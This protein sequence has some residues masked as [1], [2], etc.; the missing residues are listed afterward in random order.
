M[1]HCYSLIVDKKSSY[2]RATFSATQGLLLSKK[3]STDVQSYLEIHRARENLFQFFNVIITL[4]SPL[5]TPTLFCWKVP[6][7]YEPPPPVTPLEELPTTPPPEYPP[8]APPARK[9]KLP[10]PNPPLDTGHVPPVRPLMKLYE[11]VIVGPIL[12]PPPLPLSPAPPPAKMLESTFPVLALQQT[13]TRSPSRNN[14]FNWNSSPW[15]K[16]SSAFLIWLG[17]TASYPEKD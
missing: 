9:L 3:L 5:L 12:P 17:S 13:S 6:I 1:F 10:T 11:L 7:L 15:A 16:C 14:N 8:P 4:P 2:N